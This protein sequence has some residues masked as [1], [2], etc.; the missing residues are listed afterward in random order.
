MSRRD[1]CYAAL[2]ARCARDSME[3]FAEI[4][5]V[6]VYQLSSSLN[7]PAVLDNLVFRAILGKV[8]ASCGQSLPD[9]KKIVDGM[10]PEFATTFSRVRDAIP[11]LTRL[12]AGAQKSILEF[13]AL[14]R[15]LMR[16]CK[17]ERDHIDVIK[18]VEIQRFPPE[19][20]RIFP[21]TATPLQL[22]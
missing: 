6:K 8:A 13:R 15:M 12:M 3:V 7:D 19:K 20:G 5:G 10:P 22:C 2:D 16:K 11:T 17:I 4:L 1:L 18:A 21:P 14:K 9:L